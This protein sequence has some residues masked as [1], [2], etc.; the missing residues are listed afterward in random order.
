MVASLKLSDSG[1]L[2]SRAHKLFI[3]KLSGVCYDNVMQKIINKAYEFAKKFHEHDR[4]GHDFN[5]VR[6][7]YLAAKEILKT[8]PKADSF[9]V[10]TAALLHDIDDHKMGTDG[11]ETQRFL[12]SLDLDVN[13]IQKITD[14]V[15]AIG[16]SKNGAAPDFTTLEQKI[17]SDADKLDAMGT[18]GIIRTLCFSQA[19][20]REIFNRD[21]FP[22]ENLTPQ[23]YKD[24]S[25]ASNTFINHF[26]DKLLKLQR[27][28]QTDT[29]KALGQQRHIFMVDF[30]R[31][32][33]IENNCPDWQDYLTAYLKKNKL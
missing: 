9:V 30:L 2:F 5:H 15:G 27:A 12:K 3:D 7:V 20:K 4:T 25:R 22:E 31:H 21:I 19:I 33:F 14:T 24:L 16:F 17:V 1:T 8:E 26:F 11:H 29:G 18:M 32:F 28:L 6:R 10:L 23:R 13:T